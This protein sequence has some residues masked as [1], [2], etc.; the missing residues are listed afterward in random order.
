ML[1]LEAPS[2]FHAEISGSSVHIGGFFLTARC[3]IRG[4]QVVMDK[5]ERRG[6]P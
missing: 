2:K 1:I 5:L 6:G 3:S 4:E